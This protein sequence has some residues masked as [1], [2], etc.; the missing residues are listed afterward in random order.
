MK[1]YRALK[2]AS[3]MSDLTEQ[4]NNLSSDG[5]TLSAMSNSDNDVVVIMERTMFSPSEDKH[6]SFPEN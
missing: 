4:M 6:V 5:W 1:E 3:S 2:V